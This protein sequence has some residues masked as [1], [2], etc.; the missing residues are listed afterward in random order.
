[1]SEAGKNLLTNVLLISKE[2]ATLA[3]LLAERK[4]L[5]A[6]LKAK[7]E[8]LKKKDIDLKAKE[9]VVAEKKFHYQRDEKIL[10]EERERLVQRRKALSTL[11]NYKTQQAAIREI[12][13]SSRELNAKEEAILT[14][15][16]EIEALDSD[17][18][19]LADAVA[20]LRAEK[21]AMDKEVKETLINIEERQKRHQ[22]ERTRV[23]AL[24]DPASLS[25]Y[26]RVK[27]RSPMDPAVVVKNG[28]CSGCYMQVPPQAVVQVSKGDALI[29]C[30]GC[31]RILYLDE[32]LSGGEAS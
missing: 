5:D 26:N 15:L 2:D 25:L 16:G 19:A 29:K 10:K 28:I 1:M 23:A 18:E 31:G 12:E 30:R 4:K 21:E 11:G 32:Q 24:I 9:K 20:K 14:S 7:G 13:H 3:R 6:D 8:E 22:E 17:L 27:D